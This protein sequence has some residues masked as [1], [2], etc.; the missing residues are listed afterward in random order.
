MNESIEVSETYKSRK[1]SWTWNRLLALAEFGVIS[2]IFWADVHH[3]IYLSKTLYLFPLAGFSLWLRGLRWTDV[4]LVRFQ[5]WRRTV[6]LGV[7]CGVAME[8]FE[9]FISQPLLM[10]WTGKGPDLELF[11]AL[12]GN[13]TWTLLALAGTWTLAAFGEEMVYRGYLMNR[14]VDLIRPTRAAWG[15]SLIVV[16][17]VFGASHINQGITGQ[18]E[19]TIDG[20]LLG[21]I[22]LACGR[23]LSVSVVA[24]G[25]TDTLDVLLMFAGL[26]P[27]LR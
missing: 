27:T 21:A 10:R 11:R 22:Y 7:P 13:M 25:I 15:I 20:L 16:S 2:L 5:N 18:L 23:N 19:N 1:R 6:L 4:G 8:G 12:H 26:Y 24:H 17:C 3:H 9:L 14:V